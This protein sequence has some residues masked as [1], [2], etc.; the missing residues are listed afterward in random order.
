[1]IAV[2]D[3]RFDVEAAEKINVRTVGLLCGG[4]NRQE[5]SRAGCIAIYK[6]P[7]DLLEQYDCSPLAEPINARF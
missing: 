5:L 7:A 3:T 4:G 1:V 2:G 6:D